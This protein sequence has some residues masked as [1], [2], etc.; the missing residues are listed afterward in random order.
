MP[1][2]WFFVE[3]NPLDQNVSN[4]NSEFVFGE[5][6]TKLEIVMRCNGFGFSVSIQMYIA[7]RVN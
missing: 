2:P 6:Q 1:S 5:H 4:A 3:K 7:M